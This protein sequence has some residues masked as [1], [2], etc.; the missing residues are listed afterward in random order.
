MEMRGKTRI[1]KH[2]KDGLTKE[3]PAMV[4]GFVV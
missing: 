3:K 4:A 1:V 2:C